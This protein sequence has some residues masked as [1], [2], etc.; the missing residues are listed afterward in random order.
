[1]E[2]ERLLLKS[3]E[4]KDYQSITEMSTSDALTFFGFSTADEVAAYIKKLHFRFF[5]CS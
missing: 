3:I 2:S 5:E 1:M 4:E